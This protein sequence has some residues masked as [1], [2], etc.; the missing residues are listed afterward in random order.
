MKTDQSLRFWAN[1]HDELI[2]SL[3]ADEEK[4]IAP[5]ATA[6]EQNKTERKRIEAEIAEIKRA[7][8][9]KRKDAGESLFAR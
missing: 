7:F 6:L 9:K 3:R 1:G 8:K 5:L 4:Q 2:K